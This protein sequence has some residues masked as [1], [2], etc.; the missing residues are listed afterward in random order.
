MSDTKNDQGGGDPI[1]NPQAEAPRKPVRSGDRFESLDV[2]RGVAILGILMLNVQA[3]M[4]ASNAYIFPPAHMDITGANLNAW[5]AAYIVFDS[6]FITIFSALF[7]AGMLLMVGE[8]PDASRKLH[9]R[10]MTWLLIFGLIHMFVVWYGDILTAYALGGFIIV[11]FR[12]MSPTKLIV[13]GLIWLT[14]SGAVFVAGTWA[15]NFMPADQ[16]AENHPFL[17]PP[18][19]LRE[20]VA[21]YQNGF[22]DSR[23]PNA[24]NGFFNLATTVVIG[25]GRIIGV[26]FLG[27]ALFKLGFLT[28]RW[29]ARAYIISLV[30]GLGV[31]WPLAAFGVFTLVESGFDVGQLWIMLGCNYVAMLFVAFGYASAVMLICKAPWLKIV[32]Y[33]FACAGRMAFTNY[34]SQ[35][36]IMVFIA[37]GGIGLGQFGQLERVQQ[38]QLVVA[39]WVF[40]LVFSVAWLQLFR[41][42][43]LEWLWRSLSYGGLQPIL[44]S[45]A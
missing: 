1:S 24:L 12:R 44:K 13:W 29:S 18:D 9:Y 36:F 20:L 23:A 45:K 39:V 16:L 17:Y 21:S 37:V 7:G 5:I 40:Q 27:M 28:N 8:A 6:K 35:S 3:F 11:L 10:R 42:G 15:I 26:M 32:R 19:D 2:L 38:Y 22:L 4:M 31:G 33:P 41:M 30:I 25:W 14:L 34:L 43:P